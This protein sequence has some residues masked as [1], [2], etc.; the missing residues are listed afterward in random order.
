MPIYEYIC[1]NCG[2]KFTL[3]ILNTVEK[4]EERCPYC[5]STDIRKLISRVAYLESEDSKLEKMA[6]SFDMDKLDS[7]SPKAL[8]RFMRKMGDELGTE[9]LGPEYE[10]FIDRLEHAESFEQ[11]ERE[12]GGLEGERGE[13]GAEEGEKSSEL[14]TESSESS[15]VD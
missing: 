12:M 14:G 6:D 3:Y 13:E 9:D 10:E 11:L 5:G 1:R 7:T 15:F 2:R 4:E 8:A